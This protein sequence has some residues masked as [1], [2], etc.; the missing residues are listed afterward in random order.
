MILLQR[1]CITTKIFMG[2]IG[3]DNAGCLLLAVKY[4]LVIFRSEKDSLAYP[5]P[6]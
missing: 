2:F 5:L 4:P 3:G 1:Y 6:Q